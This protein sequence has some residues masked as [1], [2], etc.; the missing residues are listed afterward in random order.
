[1]KILMWHV[2]ESW[3]TAFVNG[4]HD[5]VVPVTPDRGE[6]G[7]GL[8]DTYL[9]PPNVTEMPPEQLRDEAFDM[10]ILQRPVEMALVQQWLGRRAGVD[11][12]AVYVEH[13]TP[14]TSPTGSRHLLADQAMIPIV[15][16][17]HFNALMWDNGTAEVHVVEH[18]IPDPGPRYS[19]MLPRASY[20]VNEPI[21]RGRVTGGDLVGRVADVAHVDVFG[22]GSAPLTS[23]RHVHDVIGHGAVPHDAMLSMLADR[24][25]YVHLCRWTS[26]GLSLL[27]AMYLGMPV[28]ALSVTETPEALAGS[29]AVVSN[30]MA[31]LKEAVREVVHEPELAAEMGRRNRAHVE[32]RYS[33]PR[34][35]ADWDR[36]LKEVQ[37]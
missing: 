17:T 14:R 9:W 36:V 6:D 20:I 19:G 25:V 2:R 24:R 16:V 4:L 29:A 35:H 31:R 21:R 23:T 30:D 15:H 11:I 27:E 5:V 34:F 1:M 10:V 26:L 13:N 28:V 18:G 12:P 22:I 7:R 33:L 3:A 8:P 37:S 32:T